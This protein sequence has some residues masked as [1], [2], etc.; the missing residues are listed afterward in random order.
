M[1]PKIKFHVD[2]GVA[3]L[4][5]YSGVSGAETGA[6][7][8]P[9]SSQRLWPTS[10]RRSCS[11][12]CHLVTDGGSHRRSELFSGPP[13]FERVQKQSSPY[14]ERTRYRG[15]DHG[16][17]HSESESSRDE[18]G[19]DE[20]SRDC[21]EDSIV[22]SGE[23]HEPGHTFRWEYRCDCSADGATGQRGFARGESIMSP[24]IDAHL[25]WPRLK[26]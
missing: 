21:T 2:K 26:S 16:R 14:R 10:R 20:Q 9:P 7:W 11:N 17:D 22:P 5:Q 19:G 24:A 3:E 23:I 15:D 4:T 8:S 18:E 1:P 12:Y 13:W 6:F 25:Q